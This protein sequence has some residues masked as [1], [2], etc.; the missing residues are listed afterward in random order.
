MFSFDNIAAVSPYNLVL[1]LNFP[2]LWNIVTDLTVIGLKDK[3]I[4]NFK[5]SNLNFEI[6][7]VM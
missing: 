5:D 1:L 3:C 6:L 4:I 7:T 2:V